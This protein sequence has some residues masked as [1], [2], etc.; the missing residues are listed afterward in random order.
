MLKN[1]FQI[2]A[3]VFVFLR[4]STPALAQEQNQWKITN[5]DSNIEIKNDGKVKVAETI[6]TN[7]SVEKHGIYRQLP[8]N[9]YNADGSK[10]FT[11]IDLLSI[12]RNSQ[13][14]KFSVSKQGDDL[15]VKIGDPDKTISGPQTYL[16][17]Y[18]V[19]GVLQSFDEYD[20]FYWNITGSHWPTDILSSKAS[21]K[22]TGTDFLSADCYTGEIGEKNTCDKTLDQTQASFE[23]NQPIRPGSDFTIAVSYP[24]NIIPILAVS[25]QKTF[26]EKILEFLL[27]A[28]VFLIP[29]APLVTIAALYVLW[30]KKGRD[31]ISIGKSRPL[32]FARSVTPEFTPPDKLRPAEIGIL[33]D[34]KADTV[35]ITATIVDLAVRGHLKIK[36][37]KTARSF[38]PDKSDYSLAKLNP[39]KP[40]SGLLPYEKMLLDSLF[41]T[42][43]SVVLSELKNTFYNDLKKIKDQAYSDLTDR[44]IFIANPNKV[45]NKYL[46]VGII[47]LFIGFFLNWWLSISGIIV[48]IFGHFMPRRSPYGFELLHRT[49]GYKEFIEKSQKYPQRFFEDKN[50]FN[51]IL[52]YAIMFGV[53]EKFA[54]AAKDMGLTPNTNTWYTGVHT[55][56]AMTLANNINTFSQS[57]SSTAAS[58]PSSS[59]SSGGGFSGG[60]FGGGGGGSW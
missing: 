4:I 36:E 38:L 12:K 49:K 52:P 13:S 41:K 25:E 55:F 45:R 23:L 22:I 7:F 24:K 18:A 37:V 56:N 28:N 51:E 47:M 59:G 46:I 11:N 57:F 9:Y 6:Q 19:S 54:K 14:E 2:I 43:N 8:L 16:I 50:L 42:K 20:E 40:Q 5:F 31:Q 39:K 15:V 32:F 10:Y 35:D 27:I 44:K 3:F 60:G 53:V 33:L 30:L 34:Q 48:I 1:L 21:V 29:I 58:R 26:G 17:E